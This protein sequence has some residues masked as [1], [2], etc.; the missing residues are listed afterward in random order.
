MLNG[1]GGDRRGVSKRNG[2]NKCLGLQEQPA[3]TKQR[4]LYFFQK[5][6]V[7]ASKE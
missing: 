5:Q 2:K 4:M 1:A 6:E 7:R 3:R